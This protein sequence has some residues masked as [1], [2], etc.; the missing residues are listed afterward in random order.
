MG[1]DVLDK[2]RICRRELQG[3]ETTAAVA[4]NTRLLKSHGANDS[5]DIARLL[6]DIQRLAF[7]LRET[8]SQVSLSIER[9]NGIMTGQERHDTIP[10]LAITTASRR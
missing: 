2:F 4:M 7:F 9:G 8:T 3:D 10:N 1:D 6:R 5:D